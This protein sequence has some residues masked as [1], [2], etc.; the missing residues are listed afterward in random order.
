VIVSSFGSSLITF[1][2]LIAAIPAV[3]WVLK[4]AQTRMVSA[5]SH[6]RTIG[7]LPMGPRERI[8]LIE[9]DDKWVLV[10]ITTHSIQ[11]LTVMDKPEENTETPAPVPGIP[12]LPPSPFTTLLEKFKH[13]RR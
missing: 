3:L 9:L 2:A 4:R 1:I 7:V 11:T 6:L 5:Q 13:G 8:A 10:G 12:T